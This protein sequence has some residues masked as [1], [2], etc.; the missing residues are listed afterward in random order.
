M[1]SMFDVSTTMSQIADQQAQQMGDIQAQVDR[2]D[3]KVNNLKI[4]FNDSLISIDDSIQ[5]IIDVTDSMMSTTQ[6][7]IEEQQIQIQILESEEEVKNLKDKKNKNSNNDPSMLIRSLEAK[8]EMMKFNVEKLLDGMNSNK[9][10]VADIGSSARAALG[11]ALAGIFGASVLTNLFSDSENPSSAETAS[12]GG[13][14]EG[15]EESSEGSGASEMSDEKAT[16]NSNNA[17]SEKSPQEAPGE[18]VEKPQQQASSESVEKPQQQ[19]SSE[20]ETPVES[21]EKPQQQASSEQETPGENVAKNYQTEVEPLND[22]A[23]QKKNYESDLD[24]KDAEYEEKKRF[25]LET[26]KK[27]MDSGSP[28][29]DGDEIYFAPNGDV[30]EISPRSPSKYQTTAI[31]TDTKSKAYNIWELEDTKENRN[32]YPGLWDNASDVSAKTPSTGNELVKSNE[33]VEKSEDKVR[34]NIAQN[35]INVIN[36]S[37]SDPEPEPKK[38]PAIIGTVTPDQILKG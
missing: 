17:I 23:G 26:R 37:E 2:L 18:D 8:V 30:I 5:K 29:K 32:L 27:A 34:A 1:A 24:R 9:P 38:T 36:K 22:M 4:D 12:E 11:V 10:S 15:S 13:N 14:Q 3:D 33:K 6:S 31:L 20:Q 7:A 16:E 28:I 25:T 35:M 19:A 21:V